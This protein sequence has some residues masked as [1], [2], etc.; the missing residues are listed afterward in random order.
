MEQTLSD[1]DYIGSL[2][3]LTA[4]VE[5]SPSKKIKR[6]TTFVTSLIDTG[7]SWEQHYQS[8]K[9]D[10]AQSMDKLKEGK[11][12]KKDKHRGS[13]GSRDDGS[14][15]KGSISHS[16]SEGISDN[17]NAL[18]LAPRHVVIADGGESN[19]S[20][21]NHNNSSNTNLNSSNTNSNSS[22]NN[23]NSPPCSPGKGGGGGGSG[24][25]SLLNHSTVD[26]TPIEID[27]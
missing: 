5:P 11:D 23:S 1:S 4:A 20:N 6:K 12:K 3:G 14:S 27:E 19:K 26:D 7:A 2:A 9:K 17:V 25:E 21:A 18:L 16:T 22:N 15:I 8:Q 24:R 10:R 13:L